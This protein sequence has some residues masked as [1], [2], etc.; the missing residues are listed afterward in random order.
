LLCHAWRSCQPNFKG[1]YFFLI[2]S[3]SGTSD[4]VEQDLIPMR[5]EAGVTRLGA[6]FP[7]GKTDTSAD[8]VRRNLSDFPEAR[9]CAGWI[10]EVFATL[11]ERDWAF[12]HLDL[13]LYEPTVASL[14]YFYPRLSTG[15]VILCDGS[16]FCPGAE[17]AWQQFCERRDVAYVTL[18]HR[19]TV[20]IK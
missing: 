16:A 11:P 4:S 15:G 13:T 9:V 8:E 1:K 10:P 19:E 12:V 6:F 2:D 18:G 3:F 20:L 17:K 7:A 14:E 5:D